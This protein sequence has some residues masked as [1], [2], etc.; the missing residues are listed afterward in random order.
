M[1]LLILQL[2]SRLMSWKDRCQTLHADNTQL[3]SSLTSSQDKCR[4]S[5]NEVLALKSR[6]TCLQKAHEQLQMKC[7]SLEHTVETL[8]VRTSTVTK[9]AS[10]SKKEI[11]LTAECKRKVKCIF[12]YIS[13]NCLIVCELS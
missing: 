3:A 9:V 8:T 12:E 7:T 11:Q 1:L 4:H 13:L 5:H 6:L 10:Q 2:S